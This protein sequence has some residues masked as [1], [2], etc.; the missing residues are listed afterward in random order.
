MWL[1]FLKFASLWLLS[2]WPF[3]YSP[4]NES[5]KTYLGPMLPPGERIWQLIYPDELHIYKKKLASL[6]MK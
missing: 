2:Y 5:C 4:Q 3:H 1:L 6:S